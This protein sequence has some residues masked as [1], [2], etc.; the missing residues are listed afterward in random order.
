MI[1]DEEIEEIVTAYM[2]ALI[3]QCNKRKAP[4][5]KVLSYITNQLEDLKRT[6]K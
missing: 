5:D 6:R 3:D 4:I 1:E 2:S